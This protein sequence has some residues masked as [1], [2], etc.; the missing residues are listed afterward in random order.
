M[1]RLQA[2]VRESVGGE[3]I[4]RVFGR[5]FLRGRSGQ[6][7]SD[8]HRKH[9]EHGRDLSVI[10]RLGANFGEYAEV[11]GLGLRECGTDDERQVPAH[12]ERY[13]IIP[14]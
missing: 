4:L 3:P 6:A 11:G 2:R 12:M 8:G 13:R 9:V 7:G 14:S 1:P 10:Y 5:T